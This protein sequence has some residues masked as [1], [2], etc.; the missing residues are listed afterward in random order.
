MPV[1]DMRHVPQKLFDTGLFDLRTHEGQ[2]AYVDAVVSVLHGLDERWGHLK[3]KPG[4]TAVH[5]HGEDA[6]L[7]L[8]DEP[9]QS[10][11]VDFVGGAG[12]PNPR[13][14]WQV[15][16]P[17]YS[18]SDW[19]DPTEHGTKAPP[20]P[21]PP[22]PVP[23][24]PYPDENTVGKAFQARVKQAF[25]DAGRKFPDPNDEDAFRLFIRFGYSSHEMP[26]DKAADKH[27]TELRAALGV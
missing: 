8:S 4:Q 3:K 11:A 15:D 26:A 16:A 13:P 17:R 10:Q 5:G 25:K 19:F 27:V 1:P 2:G 20:P 24:F 22:P 7:Y 6:A 12:G 23:Q 9:G 18:A 14:A 21:P